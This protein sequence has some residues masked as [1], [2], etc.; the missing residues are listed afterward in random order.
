MIPQITGQPSRS[1][2]LLQAVR[3]LTSTINGGSGGELPHKRYA[4][5]IWRDTVLSCHHRSPM[6]K[7][8]A[9]CDTQTLLSRLGC[10]DIVGGMIRDREAKVHVCCCGRSS[11][12]HR[13]ESAQWQASHW[14]PPKTRQQHHHTYY[15]HVHM[16]DKEPHGRVHSANTIRYAPSQA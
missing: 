15:Q 1:K 7:V 9:S 14:P 11:R 10:R 16:A 5:A 4:E 3:C 12:K 6:W 2:M 8:A 13:E